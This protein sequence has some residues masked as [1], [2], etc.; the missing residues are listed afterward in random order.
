MF[1][2]L[3]RRA[4]RACCMYILSDYITSAAAIGGTSDEIHYNLAVVGGVNKCGGWW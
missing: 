2:T 1:Y 4:V 3:P